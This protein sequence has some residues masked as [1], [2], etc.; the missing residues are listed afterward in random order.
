V[1]IAA[2]FNC[3]FALLEEV[4]KINLSRVSRFVEKLRNE[5]WVLRGKKIAIWGLSFKPDTD[6]IRFAPAISLI[7]ELLSEG[8][9]IQAYDPA[10]MEKAKE[11][12]P[13]IRYC[14]DPYDAAK[15][16]DAILLVTE[17]K[18]FRG[19]DW[20]RLASLVE[21]RLLMDGRNF[22]RDEDIA[23]QGFEYVGIG[24][25]ADR[26]AAVLVDDPSLNPETVAG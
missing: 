22:L 9:I 3:N 17:W 24:G 14:H 2:R 5:L 12:L 26:P 21:R 8:A 25:I 18:E 1:R 13:N 15:D 20:T 4:E 16:A 23:A 6:D 19:L 7:R 11:E 10:A